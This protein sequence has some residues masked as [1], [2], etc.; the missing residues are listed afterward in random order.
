MKK[1]EN[2][3]KKQVKK[4][5]VEEKSYFYFDESVKDFIYSDYVRVNSNRKGMLFSFGKAHPELD[6]FVIVN[7]VLLPLDVAYRLKQIIEDQLN[8]QIEDGV[9]QIKEEADESSN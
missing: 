6:K 3:K 2:Q 5:D 9:I 4:S 1:T 8:Q 7:E